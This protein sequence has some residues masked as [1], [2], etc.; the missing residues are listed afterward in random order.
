MAWKHAPVLLDSAPTTPLAVERSAP[1]SLI[2]PGEAPAGD[3]SQL[4]RFGHDPRR[5]VR[6][7]TIVCLICGRPMRQITNSH[8]KAHGT[9]TTA[10]KRRFGYNVRRPLMCLA[11]RRL[12]SDRS[13]RTGLATFIRQ[14]PIVTRPE[15]RA[16]GGRRALA[17]EEVLTRF[18]V[19]TR[20]DEPRTADRRMHHPPRS[21]RWRV[22]SR[23]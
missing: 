18:D 10:Y 9:T 14:R 4:A 13:V 21:R 17:W 19:R 15:L 23:A 1:T 8:L 20:R 11:L 22:V 6:D 2:A 7:D 16:L 5:A 3:L 12:Y